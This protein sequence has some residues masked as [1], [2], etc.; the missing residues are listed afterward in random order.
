LNRRSFLAAAA[1]GLPV[2]ALAILYGLSS[3][4]VATRSEP[5]SRAAAPLE[6]ASSIVLDD[7]RQQL[8]GVRVA[9]V[10]AGTLAPAFRAAGR[11]TYDETRIV[12]VN[13][14]LDGWVQNL[15]VNATGRSVKQGQPLLTLY[16]PELVSVQTQ[17]IAALKNRDQMAPA[18]ADELRARFVDGPRLRLARWDVPDDQLRLIEEGREV[19]TAVMF[20][21]P[22]A[23]VVIEKNVLQG[24][25]VDMGRTL[26]RLADVS[27]VWID[28]EFHETDLSELREGAPAEI[29]LDAYPRDR[30]TGRI[31]QVFPYL[32]PE[33]RTVK[34]RIALANRAG[35][36]RPG[37]LAN[38]DMPGA[39]RTGLLVPQDAIV[40]SGNRRTV[41]VARGEGRFEP[42]DVTVGQRAGGQALV[43]TGLREHE[44]VATRGAFFLDSESRLQAAL[45]NYRGPTAPLPA[46]PARNA[47]D[48]TVRFS[49]D[50]LRAAENVVEVQ[51][52]DTGGQPVTDVDIRVVSV[53]PPMPSMNMPAMHSETSAKHAGRG[54]Y[55]GVL[56]FSMAGRWDV[57][58]TAFR[59]GEPVATTRAA[60]VVR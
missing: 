47:L 24:M 17:Y 4:G 52:R 37:M 58:V 43:L 29:T 35:R 44:E 22:A 34:A 33:T 6:R 45:E 9:R 48:L 16:S 39:A 30:F 40:D 42:R 55:R 8:T 49:P 13:L 19:L 14:K 11:V 23:G 27:S 25:H 2:A 38:V 3:T 50:P 60:V 20:R 21:S 12:D 56:T 5:G 18:A 31:E 57:S 7:R 46:G 53:M 10:V 28:A 26:F 51:V 15:F 1:I 36:L 59:H 41:F 32:T 54:V